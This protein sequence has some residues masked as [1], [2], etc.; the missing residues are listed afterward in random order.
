MKPKL[1]FKDKLNMAS[2]K[3]SVLNDLKNKPIGH[4]EPVVGEVKYKHA[5]PNRNKRAATG[6]PGLDGIIEHGL[7]N[8]SVCLIGGSA[9]SGK[10]I[11]AMQFIFNGISQC[12]EPGVYVSFEEERENVY[13][14]MSRFGWDLGKLENEGKFAF[15]RYTPEQ[16][17][18]LLKTGGGVIRDIIDKIGAKRIVIDSISA[19]TLLYANELARREASLEL[20]K[21]LKKWGCTT[22][23]VGQYEKTEG[24]HESTAVEFEVDGII[25][26][27]NL[28]KEEMRIRAIEVFKMRGTKHSAKL[29]P[30]EIM[31]KGIKIYPEQNVF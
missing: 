26:L 8:K 12:N 19:F 11:F 25:W 31:E 24:H 15:L 6:I 2:I 13:E 16:V 4:H 7:K 27:Y 29:F 5:N 10:S 18:K 28:Q 9:G 14:N 20:F 23:V 17:G 1:F 21:L 3:Q 30:F 22:L